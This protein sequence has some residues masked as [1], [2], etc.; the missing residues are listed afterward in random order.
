MWFTIYTFRIHVRVCRSLYITEKVSIGQHK[1]KHK[2]TS[3]LWALLN[4]C[5]VLFVYFK[6]LVVLKTYCFVFLHRYITP[7][8]APMQDANV[9]LQSKKCRF[10][11]CFLTLAITYILVHTGNF[12]VHWVGM[13]PFNSCHCF[14]HGCTKYYIQSTHRGPWQTVWWSHRSSLRTGYCSR[15]GS[16]LKKEKA[17]T[18]RE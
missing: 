6:D 14:I 17:V 18:T 1:M 11:P 10:V 7:L 3:A 12:T 9:L 5:A 16:K 13:I 4:I 15:F 8:R 2:Y